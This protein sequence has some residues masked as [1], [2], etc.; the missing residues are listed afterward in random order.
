VKNELVTLAQ[1]LH[2]GI[3]QDLVGLGYSI[4][5]AISHSR[6]PETRN[7]LRA[8]RF[9][10]TEQTEKVRVEIHRLR[11]LPPYQ[12]QTTPD[13]SYQLSK[14]FGE[15][16]LNVS[17]HS[18]ATSLSIT[19]EDNGIGGA[20]ERDGSFGLMGIKERVQFL[21]GETLI[22]SDQNGTKI[23]VHIPLDKNDTSTRS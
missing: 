9:A 6:E 11:S 23:E 8:I 16:L 17:K 21:G 5:N 15:I 19:I 18:K 4:D 10:I 2:D 7:E 13:F 12:I 20:M 14:V 22:E 1:E 3:A